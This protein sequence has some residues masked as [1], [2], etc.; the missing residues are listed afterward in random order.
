M[1]QKTV[2]STNQRVIRSWC[3]HIIRSPKRS[4]KSEIH[5]SFRYNF[6]FFF[7]FRFEHRSFLRRLID[8]RVSKPETIRNSNWT[9]FRVS[10]VG[11]YARVYVTWFGSLSL[12]LPRDRFN[13]RRIRTRVSKETGRVVTNHKTTT[14][15]DVL[16]K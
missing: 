10:A 3:K 9:I 2:R 13:L 1:N 8:G 4:R 11:R 16:F 7:P 15:H 5:V 14:I 6:F 12:S